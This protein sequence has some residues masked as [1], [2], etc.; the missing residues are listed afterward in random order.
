MPGGE[1]QALVV[2]HLMEAATGEGEQDQEGMTAMVPGVPEGGTEN[3][4]DLD[5]QVLCQT[6]AQRQTA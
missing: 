6:P 5:R 1:V 3:R 4:W 2:I